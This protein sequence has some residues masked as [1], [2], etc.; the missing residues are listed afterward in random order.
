MEE[1][2][3]LN[4]INSEPKVLH[5]YTSDMADAVR[6]NEMSVIK[7]ALAEK[8]KREQEEI[9]KNEDGTKASKTI[10]IVGGIILIGVAFLISYFV[11]QK[12]TEVN[13]PQQATKEIES[14]INYNDKVFIDTRNVVSQSDFSDAVK[15]NI[16]D[17]I[18]NRLIKSIFLTKEVSGKA[19]LVPI[20]D[21]FSWVGAS[22]PSVLKRSLSETY[23]MGM[24]GATEGEGLKQHL[25]LMLQTTNYNQTYASM[26]V[27]EKTML[28]DLFPI[29]N[30]DVSGDRN[31]L[32]EKQWSD[33]ILNNKDARVLR[34]NLDKDL[35][36]YVFINKNTFII[37]DNQETIK[38]VSARL[39]AKETKPL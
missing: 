23:M 19:E 37:T 14:L 21:L 30:I 24:H 2:K 26:L 31:D 8:D 29:F 10:F 38:E 22:A 28:N 16:G 13:T 34:D 18:K 5:T 36:Y 4:S 25:F 35:L 33:I 20:N 1:N 6:D 17:P 3:N 7:I 12:N 11:I 27:W 39:L 32:L 9:Y 15:K